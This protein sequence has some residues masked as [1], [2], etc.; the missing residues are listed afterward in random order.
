MTRTRKSVP[1]QKG[2]DFVSPNFCVN[3]FW[4]S[5]RKRPKTGTKTK[6]TITGARARCPQSPVLRDEY[7]YCRNNHRKGTTESAAP[8][9]ATVEMAKSKPAEA[10][11]SQRR[12]RNLS[13]APPAN[14]PKKTK[15]R[16]QKSHRNDSPHQCII[17]VHERLFAAQDAQWLSTFPNQRI[18]KLT[19]RPCP[20]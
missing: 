20:P 6:N 13:E 18:R 12:S 16:G 10:R 4:I 3:Q 19:V 1:R 17:S 9:Q 15:N 14:E 8:D 5:A 7:S 2:R 11:I